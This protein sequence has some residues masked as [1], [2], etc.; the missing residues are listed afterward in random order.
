MFQLSEFKFFVHTWSLGV[1]V[2]F[3]LIAPF[4]LKF[5]Y[6]RQQ[7]LIWVVITMVASAMFQV[8]IPSKE[9]AFGFMLC[10]MWQFLS[11]TAAFLCS[12][13]NDQK[14]TSATKYGCFLGLLLILC[15]SPY[16]IDSNLIATSICRLL[17]T[18]LAA[19]L[20]NIETTVI[21]SSRIN[22]MLVYIGNASYSMYLVHWPLI[23]IF[24]Y[25]GVKNDPGKLPKKRTKRIVSETF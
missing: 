15:F 2:Q 23:V 24:N 5:F 11:G 8:T 25:L 13:K 16:H 3:Y 20:L 4:V 1:E 19:A 18:V 10:R 6:A 12:T 14:S 7:P 9:V 21:V 17:S 22:Q